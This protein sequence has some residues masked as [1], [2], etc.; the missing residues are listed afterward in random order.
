MKEFI[1]YLVKN[2]VDTPEKVDVRCLQSESRVLIELRVAAE[3]V[4]KVIGRRGV[5]INAI[6]IIAET[7]SARFGCKVNVELVE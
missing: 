5:I 1:E 6:R 2:L 3:D 4:G 7:V